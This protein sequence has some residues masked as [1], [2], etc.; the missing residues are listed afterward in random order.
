MKNIFRTLC[1]RQIGATRLYTLPSTVNILPYQSQIP[2]AGSGYSEAAS[3]SMFKLLCDSTS[4]LEKPLIRIPVLSYQFSPTAL[5]NIWMEIEANFDIS[6]VFAAV[7]PSL[8]WRA[9]F[10]L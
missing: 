1:G 10:S 6:T 3:N 7:V 2:S 9:E 4:S 8:A 5:G